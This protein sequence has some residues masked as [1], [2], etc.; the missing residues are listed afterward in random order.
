MTMEVLSRNQFPVQ[1]EVIGTSAKDG[2]K[3]QSQ[4]PYQEIKVCF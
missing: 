3:F 2:G 4:F 1:F